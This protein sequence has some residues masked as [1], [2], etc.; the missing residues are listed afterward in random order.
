MRVTESILCHLIRETLLSED[1]AGFLGKTKEHDY[2]SPM[3]DPTFELEPASKEKSPKRLAR[4]IKRAWGE[5]ADHKFMD[6][7]VKVHWLKDT[8]WRDSL[9][10]LM[11]I[12]GRNEISVM[13]YLPGSSNV[14]SD[15]GS[16][17]VVIK[18]RTTLA[19]N[20]MNALVTGFHS[21]VSDN[22][23]SS[24]RSSGIPKRPTFFKNMPDGADPV[25]FSGADYILDRESF[26]ANM[27]GNNELIVDNWKPVGI[28]LAN[29]LDLVGDVS[30]ATQEIRRMG[31]RI[32]RNSPSV[33]LIAQVK[34][35][36]E[37]DLPIYDRRMR[38][39]PIP[40]L[41]DALLVKDSGGTD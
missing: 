29:S 41:N 19:A 36:L 27:Q 34:A 16:L 21:D 40:L 6:S 39:V 11:T 24:H 33:Q 15:W 17:G 5:E 37:C 38:S 2:R 25:D 22:A 28:V 1:L 7:L 26:D 18:G 8:E 35:A 31:R 20:S 23:R 10:M 12:N 14:E 30:D 13:G 9:P 4:S 32:D 3:W